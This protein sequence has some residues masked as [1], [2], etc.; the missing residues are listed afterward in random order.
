MSEIL[1]RVLDNPN[2]TL[3]CCGPMSINIVDSC[4]EIAEKEKFPIVLIAS[5][6]Q[7]EAEC[8]GRGYVNNWSTE[9]FVDY[10]RSKGSTYIFTARDHGGPGQ[11]PF[12]QKN[13]LDLQ[14]SMN[15]AKKSFEVDIDSGMNFIHI[16]PSI[17]IRNEHLTF[18][19]IVER[20]FEL[21]GHVAEY[22]LSKGKRIFIELGTEEQTGSPPNIQEFE[23]FLA[24][25]ESFCRK[26]RFP[27]P[28]FTVVQTGTKVIELRNV[29]IFEQNLPA[30]RLRTIE[31]I[32]KSAEIAFRYGCFLKEHNA[33]Y[34]STENLSLRPK[35][36]IKGSNVAPEFGMTETKSLIHL[37]RTFESEREY[38]DFI[39]IVLMSDKWRKW[40]S[41]DT[42]TTLSEKALVAGHYCYSYP[43]FVEIKS[44]LSE[45]VSREGIDLNEYLKRN[46]KSSILR[47]ASAFG[48]T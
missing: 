29:G 35:V 23:R 37:L 26:N 21:Y 25:T 46:I 28:T 32:R 31:S 44:R 38:N 17:P 45:I 36:G 10:V 40:M 3:L 15:T 20:L 5:R 7:V 34:L 11:G 16:D 43:E 30:A 4:V 6:R 12:E 14:E 1:Q 41:P 47:F 18:E 27:K 42:N 13:N 39:R 19:K 24:Q 22:S 2:Q 9:E 33:D 48:L 8:L